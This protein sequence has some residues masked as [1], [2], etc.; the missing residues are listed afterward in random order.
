MKSPSRALRKKRRPRKPARPCLI[1]AETTCSVI[2]DD[3]TET[4]RCDRCR[5]LIA[6]ARPAADVQPVAEVRAA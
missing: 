6:W 4:R 1:C 2:Y 5:R 3:G